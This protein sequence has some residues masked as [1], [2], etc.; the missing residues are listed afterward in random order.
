MKRRDRQ[1]RV[2]IFGKIRA[3]NLLLLFTLI[4][5][6]A[7]TLIGLSLNPIWSGST[8]VI[9]IRQQMYLKFPGEMFMRGLKMLIVPLIIA[10]NISAIASLN[11][12][13]A[14]QLAVGPAN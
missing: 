2:P 3:E 6:V 4:A 13:A 7:G 5:V 14:R 10:S 9:T 1:Y 8:E 11:A 12:R